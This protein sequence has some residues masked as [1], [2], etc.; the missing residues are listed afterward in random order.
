MAIAKLIY[1]VVGNALNN[2]M[3]IVWNCI[4]EIV[5]FFENELF[6][7]IFDDAPNFMSKQEKISFEFQLHHFSRNLW[8]ISD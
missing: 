8:N 6:K 1:K 4:M 2:F 5:L 7:F 3:E